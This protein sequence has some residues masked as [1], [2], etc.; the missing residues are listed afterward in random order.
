MKGNPIIEVITEKPV[1]PSEKEQ[2]VDVL[3]KI[4]APDP[5][6]PT[7]RPPL[8]LAIVLDRSGSMGGE[9]IVRAREVACFCVDQMLQQDRL[10]VIAFDDHIDVVL[11]SSPI[12]NREG[13][14]HSIR[15]IEARNSTALHEAWVRGGLQVSPHLREGAVNRV[16]LIT[17][18]LANVGETSTDTIVTQ[19]GK[20]ASEGVSTSTIGIGG[21]FNEDLLVPMANAGRG[22]AWHVEEPKDMDRI[23][24]TELNGLV[25]QYGDTVS[26]GLEPAADMRIVDVLND[27]EKTDTGR[28]KLPNLV[29]GSP[30]EVV[31]RLAVPARESGSE[32]TALNLRLAW[33]PQASTANHHGLKLTRTSIRQEARFRF[34]PAEECASQPTDESVAKAVQLLMAARARREAMQRMD[35]SDYDGAQA[36]LSS[37]VGVME[38]CAP[39]YSADADFS[40]DLSE[41]RSLQ[42][43]LQDRKD[44][45]MSRKKMAY[46]SYQRARSRK[47]TSSK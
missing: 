21:D 37:A 15:R 13:I 10:A 29:A 46:Q 28:L 36:V 6:S 42:G 18:G 34:A 32:F 30:V 33:N 47:P 45:G 7:A 23:F 44:L 22:N 27:C 12:A 26:L 8:N 1:L 9:K 3:I 19:A 39:M 38:A 5:E 20:L 43:E 40:E 14:K 16:L 17:D 11:P 41:L 24:A 4:S 31:V 2:T 35:A 25:S